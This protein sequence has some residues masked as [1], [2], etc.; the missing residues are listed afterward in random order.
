MN[1]LHTKMLTTSLLAA[2]ACLSLAAPPAMGSEPFELVGVARFDNLQAALNEGEL[3]PYVGIGQSDLLGTN[4]Q[5]GSIQP[6][7]AP[8]PIDFDPVTNVVTLQFTGVQGTHPAPGQGNVHIINASG[9]KIFCTW[10]AVFTIEL[11]LD[12]GDAIFSGIGDF[13][14]IGGTGRFRNVSGSF[15][16]QFQTEVVPAG[17]D[18]AFANVT[19]SGE[20]CF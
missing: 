20:I 6:T 18:S 11:D 8:M 9:G 10:Q 15:V 13:T 14:I 17:A 1:M 19:Q 5:T 12:T 4:V 2:L 7:S 3:S 16:T